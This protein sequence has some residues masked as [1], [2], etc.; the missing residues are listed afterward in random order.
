MKKQP[1]RNSYKSAKGK[2]KTK[3]VRTSPGRGKRRG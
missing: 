2:C 1:V 3:G